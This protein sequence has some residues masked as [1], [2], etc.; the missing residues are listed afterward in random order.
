MTGSSGNSHVDMLHAPTLALLACVS[1]QPLKDSCL[2]LW[3]S[4]RV[5]QTE[6]TACISLLSSSIPCACNMRILLCVRSCLSASHV[7]MLLRGCSWVTWMMRC[8]MS[9]GSRMGSSEQGACCGMCLVPAAADGYGPHLMIWSPLGGG[10][11][12]R[13]A[14]GSS[15]LTL[16]CAAGPFVKP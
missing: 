13:A 10:A 14:Q 1:P 9:R 2:G 15:Y 3:C 11:S 6:W 8:S 4:L 5:Y 12:D 16:P 7:L